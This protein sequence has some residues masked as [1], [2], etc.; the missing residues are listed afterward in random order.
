MTVNFQRKINKIQSVLVPKIKSIK[1][2]YKGEEAHNK[3]LKEYKELGVSHFYTLKPLLGS[4]IQVPILIA[5]FNALGEMP[6]FDGHSFLWINNLAYPDSLAYFPFTIPMF[7]NSFNLLPIMM[8]A[9]T[10]YSTLIFRDRSA[11]KSQETR[12]KRNLYLMAAVFFTLFYP[13]PASMVL[14]WT[15]ANILQTVQQ[16]IIRQ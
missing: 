5:I 9:I 7:G 11:L 13:F 1:S 4:L 14:Y 16:Q 3:I 2:R 12:Q 15:L 8:T 6:Q 10:L